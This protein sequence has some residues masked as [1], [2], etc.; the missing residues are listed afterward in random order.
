MEVELLLQLSGLTRQEIIVI[1]AC[2]ADAKSFESVVVTLVERYSG[3]HLREGR[4]LGRS[5]LRK[6]VH[7]SG[8]PSRYRTGK[9]KGKTYTHCRCL[10][11]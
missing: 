8:K 3:V 10:V 4:S 9:G 2:A 11:L 5:D 7:R 1:K 6:S